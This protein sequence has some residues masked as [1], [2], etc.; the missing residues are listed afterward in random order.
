[1]AKIII[2]DDQPLVRK[3]VSNFLRHQGHQIIA[4]KNDYTLKQLVDASCPDVILVDCIANGYDSF[5]LLRTL[6]RQYPDIP[7][8]DYLIQNPND[9]PHFSR[10]LASVLQ[11]NR[12]QRITA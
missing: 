12:N 6:K 3:I 7:S 5:E 10:L 9:L 8:M 2:I 11:S 1:M 4:L